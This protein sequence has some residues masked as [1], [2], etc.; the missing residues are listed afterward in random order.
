MGIDW[1][2]G[3]EKITARLIRQ[4]KK[5]QIGCSSIGCSSTGYLVSAV[6]RS[7]LSHQPQISWQKTFW[8]A[9]SLMLVI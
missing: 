7:H 5:W 6:E 1:I 9:S 3:R 2:E 8:T 4:E